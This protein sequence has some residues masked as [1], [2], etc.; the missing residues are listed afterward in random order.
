MNHIYI[1]ILLICFLAF[2][3]TNEK[4]KDIIILDEYSNELYTD[5]VNA[6]GPPADKTAYIIENAPTKSWNHDE[7]FSKYPKGA[8]YNHVQIMEVIWDVGEYSI[9]ACFHLVNGAN[10][11]LVAKKVKKGIM[12]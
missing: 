11:C 6:L 1:L 3:C 9:F 2:Y 5:M 12:F 4:Q 7:L 8:E 10:R